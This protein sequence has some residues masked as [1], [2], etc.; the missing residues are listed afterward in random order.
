MVK[1]AGKK[2]E[3]HKVALRNVRRDANDQ[4]KRMEK[5][6]GLTKDDIKRE[7]DTVQKITD[8]FIAEADAVRVAKEA[9]IM[10]V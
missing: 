8:K 3:D 4:I 9:E 10:E 1:L 5:D 7:E 6:G 2:T